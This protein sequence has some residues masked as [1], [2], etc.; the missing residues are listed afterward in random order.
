MILNWTIGVFVHFIAVIPMCIVSVILFRIFARSKYRHILYFA[1]SWLCAMICILFFGLSFLFGNNILFIVGFAWIIPAIAFILVVLEYFSR[2]SIEPLNVAIFAALSGVTSALTLLPG[3]IT[4][5]NNPNGESYVDMNGLFAIGLMLMIFYYCVSIVYWGIQIYHYFPHNLKR[6]STLFLLTCVIIAI[7]F[8]GVILFGVENQLPG[9]DA[10]VLSIAAIIFAF[11]FLNKPQVAFI[12]PFK[13]VQL[14]IIDT[15]S[16][17]PLFTHTW[18][19]IGEIV[20]EMLFSGMFQGISAI[21]N[22]AL[23]RGNVR[24]IVLDKGTLL[25]NRSQEVNAACILVTNKA[26]RSLRVALNAFADEFFTRFG[27]YLNAATDLTQLAG[28]AELIKTH[29]GFIPKYD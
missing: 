24:E 18:G 10:V 5:V 1:L 25:L 26:T 9:L 20:D 2:E 21:L 29:F 16:G 23:H 14:T 27:S 22:E 8:L 15:V 19:R 7:G 28:V 6:H 4:V 3:A 11:V 12:L 17:I 13:V